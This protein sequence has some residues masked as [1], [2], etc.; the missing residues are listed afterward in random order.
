MAP[1]D[2]QDA[3]KPDHKDARDDLDLVLPLQKR[4]QQREGQDGR[5]HSEQMASSQKA[6]RREE[7]ARASFHQASRYG[8]RPPHS[9]VESMVKAAPNDGHPQAGLAPVDRTQVDTEG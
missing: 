5:E 3:T 9:R 2:K 6:K 1:P 4:G 7:G 8:K